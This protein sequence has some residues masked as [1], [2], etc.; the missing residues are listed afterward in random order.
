MDPLKISRINELSKKSKTAGLTPSEK[1]EQQ[2]LRQEYIQAFRGNLKSTLDS[3]V[4]VDKSGN[5]MPLKQKSNKNP[6]Q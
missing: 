1:Q 4:V 2:I 6:V 3:I 5:K